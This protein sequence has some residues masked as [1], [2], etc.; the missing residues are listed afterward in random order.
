MIW[1]YDYSAQLI[2]NLILLVVILSVIFLRRYV[3]K[4]QINKEENKSS[5]TCDDISTATSVSDTKDVS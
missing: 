3:K 5:H 2:V 1:G 4:K